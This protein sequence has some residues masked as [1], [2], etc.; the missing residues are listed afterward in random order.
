MNLHATTTTRHRRIRRLLK[1]A[2]RTGAPYVVLPVWRLQRLLTSHDNLRNR[3]QVQGDRAGKNFRYAQ[4]LEAEVARYR[5]Q[6]QDNAPTPDE[7]L[8]N[9]NP[10]L[11]QYRR[12]R[13]KHSATHD[14]TEHVYDEFHRAALSLLLD[15]RQLV[16]F[17]KGRGEITAEA[18]WPW[19]DSPRPRDLT[20]PQRAALAGA[21][22]MCGLDR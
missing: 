6:A 16:T 8:V 1:A 7:A 2:S 18:L 13:A 17:N 11:Q 22:L 21:L 4:E 12:L 5:Q 9:S 15:E 3:A 10:V 19:R 20:G 14:R